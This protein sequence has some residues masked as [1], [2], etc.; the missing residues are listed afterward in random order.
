MKHKIKVTEHGITWVD[1][2]P[3]PPV[4][5]C[6]ECSGDRIM[7]NSVRDC[8]IFYFFGLAFRRTADDNVCKDCGCHFETK[9]CHKL[10]VDDWG[11][12]FLFLAL[13]GLL[14]FTNWEA[15]S[16]FSQI[17]TPISMIGCVANFLLFGANI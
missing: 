15:P 8:D 1:P 7:D 17:A 5:I 11:E 14:I 10:R 2:T 3:P 16:I 6:P 13:I 4:I 9:H 12:W